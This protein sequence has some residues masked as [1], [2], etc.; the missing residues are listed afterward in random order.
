M[1]LPAAIDALL[2]LLAALLAGG[3]L[4]GFLAGL[5]GIG[6]GAVIVPVLYELFR[7][8]GVDEGIR[9]QLA[10][11]TS[12]AVMLPTTYRSFRGHR[13]KGAVDMVL[14]RRLA[15]PLVIGVGVGVLVASRAPATVFKW[16]WIAFGLTM[17]T[18]LLLG[19]RGWR[20]GTG[21][22]QTWLL[23]AYGGLVGAVSTL[24]SIGGGAFITVMLRLFGRPITEAV[25]TASAFG[26]M[27]AIPGTL[28]FIWAGWDAGG[29]PPSS[30][31]FVSLAGVL[32][33]APAS[34]MAAPYGVRAAHGIPR[35]RLEIAFAG[36]LYVLAGRFL[37]TL[38]V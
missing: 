19:D 8:Y 30:L 7:V 28:G 34:L 33:A 24:L 37:I 20:L 22:P 15:V 32:I 25:G 14:V 1:Q 23:E 2:P 6:G 5:F 9:L 26:P 35:R 27:I 21:L 36:F 29:L 10:T 16:V 17:G 11:G 31:G 4:M 38:A 18:N 3:L 12:L 13:A